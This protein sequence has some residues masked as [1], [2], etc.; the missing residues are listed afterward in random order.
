VDLGA[1][2]RPQQGILKLGI[3]NKE[4]FSRYKKCQGRKTRDLSLK[5]I[6]SK[7]ISMKNNIEQQFFFLFFWGGLAFKLDMESIIMFCG[8]LMGHMAFSIIK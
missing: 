8:P 7:S 6:F 5:T 4:W 1:L 2:L 3:K